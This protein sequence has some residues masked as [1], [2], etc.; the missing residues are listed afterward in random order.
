MIDA[1][2]KTRKGKYRT[3]PR[4]Q[5][6]HIAGMVNSLPADAGG[7]INGRCLDASGEQVS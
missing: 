5:S 3:A 4:G 1:K 7:G 6:K 2:P